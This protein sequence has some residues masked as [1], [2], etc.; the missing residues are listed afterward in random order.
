MRCTT[1]MC[2]RLWFAWE[3]AADET[4]TWESSALC[5]PPKS[6]SNEQSRAMRRLKDD[7]D[8]IQDLAIAEIKGELKSF[9][10]MVEVK[11]D[12]L[13]EV[14]LATKEQTVKTNGRVT[15][16]EL[17]QML[18]KGAWMALVMGIGG[19]A[20]LMTNILLK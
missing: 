17:W 1:A 10:E 4:T 15:K 7:K 13:M 12:Q 3:D 18:L 8:Q 11:L 16:L 6:R 14:Q 19:I 2:I 9:K 20:W 5:P